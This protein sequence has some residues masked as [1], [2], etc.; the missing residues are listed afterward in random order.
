MSDS[1][2][3][4]H[5]YMPKHCNLLNS[6]YGMNTYIV[7]SYQHENIK[8]WKK[9]SKEK[10]YYTRK[11]PRDSGGYPFKIGNRKGWR[12]LKGKKGEIFWNYSLSF[13]FQLN[14]FPH[15]VVNPHILISDDKGFKDDDRKHRRS[16][17]KEWFNRHWYDR[18]FAFMN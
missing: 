5:N 10:I 17:P 11:P 12:T 18:I 8:C 1:T 16:I 15:Y 7:Q 6:Q 14:P 2:V 3:H 9:K 13:K 4:C